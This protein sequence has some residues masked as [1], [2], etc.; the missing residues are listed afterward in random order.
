MNYIIVDFEMNPIAREYREERKICRSEIIEIGAVVMDENFLVLGEFKTLVKPQFNDC[1]YEKYETLTGISTQ[2][3]SNAPT[4]S[5]AYEMFISWITSYGK[6]YEIYSWSDSDY[7]QLVA[8]MTLKNYDKADM[9]KPLN[10]WFDFQR[11][12][13]DKLGLESIMSLEKALFYADITFEGRQHSALCDA[14]NT[15]ELFAIAR[16]E[17]RCQEVLQTVMD[18]LKP[19]SVSS[20]LG[21]M[22]DFAALMAQIA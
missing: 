2:M 18:A 13:T 4:F 3:V 7:C 11:E 21:D 12:Y 14:R 5:V 17:K 1:I 15:A 19:K 9:M 8:E 20:A 16:D 22:I 6:E 10:H